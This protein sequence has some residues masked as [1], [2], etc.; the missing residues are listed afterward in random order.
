MKLKLSFVCYANMLGFH[1][2]H[3]VTV[4]EAKDLN[5]LQLVFV[6]IESTNGLFQFL[7]THAV[8]YHLGLMRLVY[9]FDRM[10]TLHSNMNWVWGFLLKKSY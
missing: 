2:N 9:S 7:E 6:P 3:L 10:Q 4:M 1:S 5:V 8:L